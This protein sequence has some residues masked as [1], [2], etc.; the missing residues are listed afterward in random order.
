MSSGIQFNFSL[1]KA[2]AVQ[3]FLAASLENVATESTGNPEVVA[4]RELLQR[5]T[6]KVAFAETP[7]PAH[8]NMPIGEP[9]E[10]YL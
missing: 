1:V 10:S 7:I 5:L 2:K 4:A 9:D 6:D 3:G 8:Q